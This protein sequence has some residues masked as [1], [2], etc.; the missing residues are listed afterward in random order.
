MAK[1]KGFKYDVMVLET[2]N[3]E[4]TN[5]FSGESYQLTPEE[6]AVYDLTKG[7]EMFGQY[8]IVRA[9]IEWFRKYNPKAY[10]CLLD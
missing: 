4:V 9:G 2:E 7:A 6:V 5:P 8:D 3:V 10:M 1:V